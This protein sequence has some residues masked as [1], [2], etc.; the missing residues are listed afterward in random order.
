MTAG[1]SAVAPSLDESPGGTLRVLR[2]G[3]ALPTEYAPTTPGDEPPAVPADPP[4]DDLPGGQGLQA[5]QGRLFL[6]FP[7]ETFQTLN[8]VL[9]Q[10]LTQANLDQRALCLWT[11]YTRRALA[12][13]TIGALPVAS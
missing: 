4:V 7:K 1:G 5:E 3:G 12:R 6:D 11:C 13:S 9:N 8:L 2:V 10:S